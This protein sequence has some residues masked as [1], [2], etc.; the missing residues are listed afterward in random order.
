MRLWRDIDQTPESFLRHRKDWPQR[1]VVFMQSSESEEG[2]LCH[3]RA[4][5]V[6][7]WTFVCGIE[8]LSGRK[9]GWR[10][11][12]FKS[13]AVERVPSPDCF[14]TSHDA[15]IVVRLTETGQWKACTFF[16]LPGSYTFLD[17]E[18]FPTR[19]SYTT[20][21]LGFVLQGR[22]VHSPWRS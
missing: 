3:S 6:A 11:R 20:V 17:L 16:T 13:C 15:R 22:A 8:G 19:S 7:G 10:V 18:M 21:S 12:G 1:R 5:I 4:P 9:S 14:T 2:I